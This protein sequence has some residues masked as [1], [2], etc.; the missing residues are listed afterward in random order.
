[1]IV[2]ARYATSS[3]RGH[4]IGQGRVPGDL[5]VRF[6]RPPDSYLPLPTPLHPDVLVNHQVHA[7]GVQPRPGR[8]RSNGDAIRP[9]RAML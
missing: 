3:I 6:P 1:L 4:R 2:I 8:Q 9:Q 5:G 7:Q